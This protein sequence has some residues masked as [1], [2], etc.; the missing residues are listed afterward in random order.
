M[1]SVVE[2]AC[3]NWSGV[4][5]CRNQLSESV[6]G[7]DRISCWNW[8]GV[9]CCRNRLLDCLLWTNGG[10]LLPESVVGIGCQNWLL[11]L[12]V[13]IGCRNQLSESTN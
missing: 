1:E 10:L 8:N 9:G 11:E 4:S 12:V 5:C 7:I 2:I 3:W 13:G 6:K